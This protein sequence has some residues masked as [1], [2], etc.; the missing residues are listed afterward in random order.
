MSVLGKI[1]GTDKAIETTIGYAKEIVDDAFYTKQEQ[2]ADRTRARDKAQDVIVEWLKSTTGS[3][4]A[5]RVL[6][7]SIA[8]TWLGMKLISWLMSF[9][10]VW[11]DS[12]AMVAK[13]TLSAEL[14]TAESASMGGAVTLILGFY[15]A[16]PYLGEIATGTLNKF[17]KDSGSKP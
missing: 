10:A 9:V 15:F 1:F 13:L 2:A 7:F 17:N 5:R 6:A 3:R 4:L 14:A 12:E 16:A 8:G 11:V